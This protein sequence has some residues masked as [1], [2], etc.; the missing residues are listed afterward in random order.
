[1]A[2]RLGVQPSPVSV[3]DR[4]TGPGETPGQDS[5]ADADCCLTPCCP[6]VL[7]VIISASVRVPGVLQLVFGWCKCWWLA[8]TCQGHRP[9]YR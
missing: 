6:A 3:G 7:F 2:R 4:W 8:D 9:R 5:L 1:M